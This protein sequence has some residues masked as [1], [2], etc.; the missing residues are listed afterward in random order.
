YVR[1]MQSDLLSG[2]KRARAMDTVARNVTSLTQIVEDVLD[3]SRIVSGNLRLNMQEVDLAA[4]IQGAADTV[5]PAADAKGVQLITAVD[6]TGALV[7]GDPERLQQVLWNV[8]SN[9]VKFTERGGRAEVRLERTNF[10]VE[11]TVSDTGIGIPSDFLPHVFDRFRQ[12][13]AGIS[14]TRGGLGLGLAIARHLVELQGGRMFAASDGPGTGATFRIEL[15]L[16]T[17]TAAVALED[18]EHPHPSLTIGHHISVPPLHGVRVLA[19]DDDAD[20]LAL[21]REILEA[22]GATVVTADSADAAL[23]I[24]GR[25]APD[26]MVVDLGLPRM[27]GLEFIARVRRPES[28]PEIRDIPAAALTAYAR[29]EDRAGALQSGFQLHLSKPVDPGDLMAAV[30][31]LAKRQ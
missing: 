24:L 17:S 15:P 7:A 27:S 13:D 9:A 30:A 10:H 31:S 21:V 3:V 4:V 29:S 23:E 5:R 1:M 16:R 20:A 18:N 22:T 6:P 12:A 14:R 28:R 19:V 2:E 11:I 25:I 26:V 8:L